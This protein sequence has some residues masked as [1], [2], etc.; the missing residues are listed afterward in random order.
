MVELSTPSAV[1][2]L[3]SELAITITWMHSLRHIGSNTAAQ[4]K[5]QHRVSVSLKKG[6]HARRFKK[7][8]GKKKMLSRVNTQKM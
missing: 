8:M 2:K 1:Q 6:R 5:H 4:C 3:V 7:E